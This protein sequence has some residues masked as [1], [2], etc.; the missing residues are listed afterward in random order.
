[1]PKRLVSWGVLLFSFAMILLAYEPADSGWS[2]NFDWTY[3]VPIITM[4][5]LGYWIMGGIAIGLS[6]FFMIGALRNG[7]HEKIEKFVHERAYYPGF[8]VFWIVYIIGFIKGVG[9]V[10][11]L[12][13]PSWIVYLVFFSGLVLFL[14]IPFMYFKG[15]SEL[16]RRHPVLAVPSEDKEFDIKGELPSIDI[17]LDEVRRK[18]DFQ[19]EQLDGLSTK[20]GIALGV[21]GVIFTLLVT[22][23]LNQSSTIPNLYLAKTALIPIFISLVLSFVPIYIIKWHRPPNLNRLRDYYI[24]KKMESTKLNVID[25]CLEGVDINQKLIDRLFYLI[26]CSYILLLI[27]LALLAVWIGIIIW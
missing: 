8:I 14:L 27:G 1:M 17:V 16:K 4:P 26:K 21:A 23:L 3:H 5:N 22:N 10:I 15:L 19:F 20:S 18:L 2:Y 25:K 13:P 12:S 7:W 9:A 6:L 24:V 11:S